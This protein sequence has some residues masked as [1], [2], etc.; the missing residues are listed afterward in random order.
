MIITIIVVVKVSVGA[1]MPLVSASGNHDGDHHDDHRGD[2]RGGQSLGRCVH[3]ACVQ[4]RGCWTATWALGG[5]HLELAS[6]RRVS[7]AIIICSPSSFPTCQIIIGAWNTNYH[8]LSSWL[9]I[10]C[11][12]NL[13]LYFPVTSGYQGYLLHHKRQLA[14]FND[15]HHALKTFS[16]CFCDFRIKGS[17]GWASFSA[18]HE[19]K[20]AAD[21]HFPGG[22][23]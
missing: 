7:Q 3:A 14:L 20:R 17:Y 2:H 5:R 13:G 4:V 6:L 18:A 22:Q 10:N 16:Y 12:V 9:N 19:M 23:A 1:F 11:V 8:K 15:Y 21:H